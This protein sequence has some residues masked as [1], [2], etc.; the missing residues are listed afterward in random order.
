M[1][2]K[3]FLALLAVSTVLMLFFTFY[4]SSWLGSIGQPSTALDGYR[5]HSGMSWTILLAST[6]VLLIL[7]NVILWLTRRAWALWTTLLYFA[8]FILLRYFW[9]NQAL[10]EF[11]N[12]AGHPVD[13]SAAGPLIG[14]MIVIAAAVFIFCDQFAVLQLHRKMYPLTADI[15]REMME[16]PALKN[17][18]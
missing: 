13:E 12:R 3:I 18:E 1:L 4:A 7:S 16:I 6:I 9:L 8:I 2:N 15:E 14:A 10:L 17:D 5:Y 11:T